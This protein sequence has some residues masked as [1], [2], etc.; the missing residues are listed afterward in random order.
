MVDSASSPDVY[1]PLDLTADQLPS[2]VVDI[3]PQTG[4]QPQLSPGDATSIFG[5][6]AGMTSLFGL[7]GTL[8]GDV[9][10][11]IADVTGVQ[12]TDTIN[13]LA[14][15]AAKGAHYLNP[16][17]W[18]PA[19]ES[20]GQFDATIGADAL[21]TADT[22]WKW[23]TRFSGGAFYTALLKFG[24]NLDPDKFD[25]Q[26]QRGVRTTD[27]LIGFTMVLPFAIA[28]IQL[29]GKLPLAGRFAEMALEAVKQLPEEMGLSWA[30]G[31][32]LEKGFEAAVGTSI[33]R[34]ILKQSKP[35]EPEWPIVRTMLR[36]HVISD[37]KLQEVLENSGFSNEWITAIK[38]LES[39]PLPVGDI[40]ALYQQGLIQDTDLDELLVPLAFSDKNRELVKQLYITKAETASGAEIRTVWRTLFRNGQVSEQEYR[41]KLASVNFPQRLIDDDVQAVKDELSYGWKLQSIAVIKSDYLHH[42]GTGPQAV[43]KLQGIGY[44]H[45]DAQAMVASWTAPPIRREHGLTESQTL[46]YLLAGILDQ[47][48]ART[49]LLAAGV[50]PTTVQFLLN[51]PTVVSQ[52]KPV[53]L[54]PALVTQAFVNGYITQ[55]QYYAKLQDV[56]LKGDVLDYT[57]R[58][59]IWKYNHH[60]VPQSGTATL[61][62][63]EIREAYKFGLIDEQEAMTRLGNLGYGATDALL[64]LEITNKG[65]IKAPPAAIFTTLLQAE[66]YL[67]GLGFYLE[68]AQDPTY[69]A[70]LQMVEAAGITPI[71]PNGFKPPIVPVPGIGGGI[72]GSGQQPPT[73]PP[74]P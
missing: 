39:A 14:V 19:E 66:Q 33:E 23:V 1:V 20:V 44:S 50:D 46:K 52:A 22:L 72:P 49:N 42:P 7:L 53:R 71:P 58:N 63:G 57:Y 43:S 34:A 61:D 6:V 4:P 51:H 11:A 35:N 41:D 40:Q 5:D 54:T 38:A 17:D 18:L 3:Q 27:Q 29:A 67:E 13:N 32:T 12:L 31:L 10:Q 15:H 74:G 60:H 62:K 56:G 69:E 55:D 8:A 24:L 65:P 45:D 37:D 48:Q 68:G 36:Q 70:A 2:E 73:L 30:M 28:I 21:A 9:V 16:A 25:A 64:L 26:A 59:G 47:N